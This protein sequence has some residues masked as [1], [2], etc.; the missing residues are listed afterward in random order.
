MTIMRTNLT[1]TL[2]GTAAVMMLV[3]MGMSAAHAADPNLVV[4]PNECSECH[5]KETVT[6]QPTKSPPRWA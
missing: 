3:A 1:A 2:T 4:G 5:K 6:R